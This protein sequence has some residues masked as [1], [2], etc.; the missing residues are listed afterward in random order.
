MKRLAGFGNWSPSDCSHHMARLNLT[1]RTRSQ[2]INKT[3]FTVTTLTGSTEASGK[4]QS[5]A[6]KQALFEIQ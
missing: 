2:K 4:A 6:G 5:I 1:D 3:V